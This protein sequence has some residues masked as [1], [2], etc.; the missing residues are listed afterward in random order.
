VVPNVPSI[1]RCRRELQSHLLGTAVA[2]R[3]H[4]T[5]NIVLHTS[6]GI[7]ASRF[8]TEEIAL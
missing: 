4:R 7:I 8:G 6:T 3:F 2:L 5:I 1:H